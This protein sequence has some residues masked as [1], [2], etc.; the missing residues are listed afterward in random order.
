M[1]FFYKIK[2]RWCKITLITTP[3]NL[4][5][6][7]DYHGKPIKNHPKQLENDSFFFFFY[8]RDQLERKYIDYN[9]LTTATDLSCMTN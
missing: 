8:K 5:C 6:K 7:M 4:S 9:K 3:T 1:I 2:K